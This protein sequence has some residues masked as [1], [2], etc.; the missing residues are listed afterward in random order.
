MKVNNSA[1]LLAGP[2]FALAS[3][4]KFAL[5]EKGCELIYVNT[6][7]S[8]IDHVVLARDC[9]IFIDEKRFRFLKIIK[10]LVENSTFFKEHLVVCLS[11]KESLPMGIDVGNSVLF[12][13]YRDVLSGLLK[14]MRKAELNKNLPTTFERRDV[15]LGI[16]TDFLIKCGISPKYVGFDYIVQIVLMAVENNFILSKLQKDI[17]PKISLMFKVPICNIERNIRSAIG[18]FKRSE[19]FEKILSLVVG[20]KEENITTKTFLHIVLIYVQNELVR[21]KEEEKE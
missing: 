4:L 2:D 9:I 1:L 18:Y 16:I 17:Y 8:F 19:N 15:I 6:F 7:A 14:I 5:K 12:F 3:S 11:D 20:E 21:R 13:N 10:A